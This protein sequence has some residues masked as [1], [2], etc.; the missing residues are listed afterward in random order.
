MLQILLQKDKVVPHMAF[1][2][3][4]TKHY[5]KSVLEDNEH[6]Y[7]DIDNL[8]L[9]INNFKVKMNEEVKGLLN[10]LGLRY[11]YDDAIIEP[12]RSALLYEKYGFIMKHGC[13][14]VKIPSF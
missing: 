11:W 7:I 9:K 3:D 12:E 1:L 10:T 8:S 6:V 14:Q 5:L 2:T 4:F 13:I